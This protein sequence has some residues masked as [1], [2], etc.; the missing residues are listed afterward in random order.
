MDMKPTIPFTFSPRASSFTKYHLEYES[1]PKGVRVRWPLAGVT[2]VVPQTKRYASFGEMEKANKGL[3]KFHG[4]TG[5]SIGNYHEFLIDSLPTMMGYRMGKIE[6][7]FASAT[8]LMAYLFQSLHR[9]KYFG[10][11]ENIFTARIFGAEP[12]E[13]ELAF[14]NAAARYDEDYGDLPEI[15]PMDEALLFG[16]EPEEEEPKI[17]DRG[18]AVRDIA[19][20]RFFY[21]GRSQLDDTAACIYLYRVLEYYSFLFNRKQISQLRHDSSLGDEDF[22]RRIF[23]VLAKDDKG[24]FL[25]LI[26]LLSDTSILDNAVELKLIKNS[27]A[28][29]L[30]ETLYSF[31]NSIVHGK[32]AQGYS[33]HSA[34]V[35]VED[36]SVP[37][38]RKLLEVLA[39]K[40]LDVYG[41]R[42]I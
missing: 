3:L 1:L 13:A 11:W 26:N 18:P 39:R 42:L 17:L 7:S 6:V 28:A 2:F 24:P 33:L 21:H 15:F 22:S 36:T 8:P 23:E 10:N 41:S 16:E 5:F 14:I 12:E 27:D 19:P 35:F 34:A 37:N 20:L 31:R 30:G 4:F 25:R 9:E 40:A 29:L 32:N 38:W